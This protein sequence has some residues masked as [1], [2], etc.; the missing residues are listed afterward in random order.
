MLDVHL[1]FVKTF[2]CR[3]VEDGIPIDIKP[4]RDALTKGEAHPQ[5]FIAIGPPQISL[6]GA[7]VMA[8]TKITTVKTADDRHVYAHWALHLKKTTVL[9]M[10]AEQGQRINS[11]LQAWHPDTQRRLLRIAKF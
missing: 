6:P 7:K 3:I 2:G 5:V 8:Y 9:I 4:F 11:E 10:Y 1:Y